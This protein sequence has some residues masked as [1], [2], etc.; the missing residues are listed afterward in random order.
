MNIKFIYS[1]KKKGRSNYSYFK[2]FKHFIKC[3]NNTNFSVAYEVVSY[4][5]I[6]FNLT[7][8]MSMLPIEN[9]HLKIKFHPHCLGSGSGLRERLVFFFIIIKLNFSSY[10]RRESVHK[11]IKI[12]FL[13]FCS[14]H[15]LKIHIKSKKMI[16]CSILKICRTW[17]QGVCWFYIFALF[18]F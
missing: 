18:I 9:K 7:F 11:I 2:I 16:K 15:N 4:R 3:I 12:T 6:H 5:N 10:R 8:Y 1:L 13:P 14:V 17:D